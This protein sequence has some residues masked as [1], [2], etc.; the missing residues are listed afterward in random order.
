MSRLLIL[1]AILVFAA[2]ALRTEVLGAVA[3]ILALATLLSRFWL[4]RA[5]RGLRVRR[6]VPQF[7]RY[8]EEA[9]IDLQIHNTSLIRVPWLALRESVAYRLRTTE[10]RQIVM[11]LGAGE[12][13]H[14]RYTIRGTRRGWYTLGP[15]QIEM[16]DVLGMLRSRMTV[17]ASN[18]TIYPEVL[19]LTELGLPADLSFGP[20]RPVGA[21]MISEDPAR[22]AGVRAY[23]PGDDVRR[24]DWKSSARQQ[25]LLVRR[26]DPTIAPE[27]TIALAFGRGDYPQQVLQDAVERA[28]I[29]AA[30]FG[31]AL[32]LHKLPVS[33]VT[34]GADPQHGTNGMALPFG[35]GDGQRQTLLAAIGRLAIGSDELWPLLHTQSLPWGG[36]L[37]LICADL[38]TD[39][40][41]QI[42]T[43]RRHGQAIV[44]VLIEGSAAGMALAHQQRLRAYTVDRR[45]LPQRLREA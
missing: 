45:G 42:V 26:A 3:L 14:L 19:P 12:I 32:L 2:I 41:P 39:M 33:F 1:A 28:A 5:E 24:L 6:T 36:T 8:G 43:M 18:V 15:L 34:N 23:V 35:R 20:L 13:R 31:V 37:L 22:P 7:L 11:T 27:T 25:S 10:Q 21:R 38:T 17:P 44:L 4:R 29:V 40:L 9:A 16:G 30:S